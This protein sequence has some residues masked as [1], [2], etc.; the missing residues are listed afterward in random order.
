M[1]LVKLMTLRPTE[2]QLKKMI[3]HPDSPYIRVIAMFF[4]RYTQVGGDPPPH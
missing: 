1:Y 2:A 4:V 3:S